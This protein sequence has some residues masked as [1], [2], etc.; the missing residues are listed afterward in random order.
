MTAED[1]LKQKGLIKEG[2][3][4]F[5]IRFYDGRE[6]AEL[7]HLLTEYASLKLKEQETVAWLCQRGQHLIVT[8][9]ENEKHWCENNDYQI[10]PLIRK[11]P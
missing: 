5:V 1:F 7:C 8:N 3:T 4:E 10:T 11:N 9:D 6:Q 2:N